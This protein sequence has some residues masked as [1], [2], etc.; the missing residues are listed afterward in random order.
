MTW[1]PL[2]A[3]LLQGCALDLLGGHRAFNPLVK[4][5][6]DAWQPQRIAVLRF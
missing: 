3:W 1:H 4:L 6:Y 2:F 5:W